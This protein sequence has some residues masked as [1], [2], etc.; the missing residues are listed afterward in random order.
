VC[1]IKELKKGGAMKINPP[2]PDD[3]TAKKNCRKAKGKWQDGICKNPQCGDNARWDD[4]T[5]TCKEYVDGEKPLNIADQKSRCKALGNVWGTSS[6][7]GNGDKPATSTM[8]EQKTACDIVGT[9]TGTTCIC[10]NMGK[11]NSSKKMCE[12]DP[13]TQELKEGKCTFKTPTLGSNNNSGTKFNLGT[14]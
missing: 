9:W 14:R 13:A 10:D 8:D 6:P 11:W 7:F 3:E 5:Q 4:W 1:K 12:C 2:P